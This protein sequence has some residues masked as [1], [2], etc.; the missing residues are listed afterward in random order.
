MFKI[1]ARQFFYT[2]RP[3]SGNKYHYE[4][5]LYF[6]VTIARALVFPGIC[7]QCVPQSSQLGNA[8]HVVGNDAGAFDPV[9]TVVATEKLYQEL[10][11]NSDKH[12]AAL[13]KLLYSRFP[14]DL[15]CDL[16]TLDHVFQF[17]PK[18]PLYVQYSPW[19]DFC[20]QLV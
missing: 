18:V 16:S 14:I 2:T 20:S 15:V 7:L 3:F 13:P 9:A 4:N 11:N 5:C 10:R 17:L 1:F 12:P 8:C 19:S 6:V